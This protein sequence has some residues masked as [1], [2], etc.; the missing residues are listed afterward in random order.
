M[1]LSEGKTFDKLLEERYEHLDEI[2]KMTAAKIGSAIGAIGGATLGALTLGHIGGVAGA[3]VGASLTVAGELERGASARKAMKSAKN[4][5]LKYRSLLIGVI[6]ILVLYTLIGF[7]LLPWLAERQMVK[8]L[9]QRLGVEASVEKIH[10]NP[11]TFEAS[12]DKLQLANEQNEPLASWDRFYLNL[13]PLQLFQL[14]L[15]IEEITLAEPKLHFR[16]YTTSDNTLTRL[17]ESWNATAEEEV[18]KDNTEQEEAS[19]QAEPLFTFEIGEFN[20]T[21][22]EIAYRDD[23]PANQFETVR[24][25]TPHRIATS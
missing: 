16:R 21:D 12:V 19:E 15:R 11:Y 7:L 9:Q 8:T 4:T 10:F 17:A 20:Y 18:A 14:K 3:G 24:G 1:R 23:V 6:S 2:S 25:A 5:F 13:Q 22:G